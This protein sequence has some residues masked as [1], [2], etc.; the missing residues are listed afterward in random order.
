VSRRSRRAAGVHLTDVPKV[1]RLRA[2]VRYFR[3]PSAS[4]LGKLFV[5]AA[6]AY[7]VWPMDLIPDVPIVG[8]LDDLGVA[9]I[10]IAFLGRVAARY[11]TEDPAGG[12]QTLRPT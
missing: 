3:D 7:V 1:G 5:L 10:A 4:V 8:W 6:A 2:L 9:G 12:P 11:R